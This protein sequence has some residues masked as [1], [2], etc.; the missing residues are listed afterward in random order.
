L[1]FLVVGHIH[2]EID[3]NFGYLSKKI[4]RRKGII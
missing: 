2:E 3:E 1:G 4:E